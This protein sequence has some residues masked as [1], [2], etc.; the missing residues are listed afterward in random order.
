MWSLVLLVLF[1]L[2]RGAIGVR[3]SIYDADYDYRRSEAEEFLAKYELSKDESME[4]YLKLGRYDCRNEFKDLREEISKV[5]GGDIP[6]IDMMLF[7]YAAKMGKIPYRMTGSSCINCRPLGASSSFWNLSGFGKEVLVKKYDFYVWYDKTIREHGME[8]Q[9]LYAPITVDNYLA[10][11]KDAVPISELNREEFVN[12]STIFWY[13]TRIYAH[14][15][16]YV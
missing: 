12:M 15:Y 7:G 6:S 8:Y 1:L 3:D 13:P 4:I 9:L 16:K 2:F 11:L 14:C 10:R 5:I